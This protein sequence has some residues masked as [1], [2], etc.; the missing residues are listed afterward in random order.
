MLSVTLI[1]RLTDS[2]VSRFAGYTMLWVVMVVG[3]TS[4]QDIRDH[5]NSAAASRSRT[6]FS[7]TATNTNP[8]DL[9]ARG[10]CVCVLF[11]CGDTT[12]PASICHRS[13]QN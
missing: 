5:I 1:F 10:V 4:Q 8:L 11:Y 3:L 9:F 7:A 2:A 13:S 6:S 12:N